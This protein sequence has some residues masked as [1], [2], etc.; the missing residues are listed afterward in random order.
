MAGCYG[1]HEAKAMASLEPR[2]MNH[3]SV[4]IRWKAGKQSSERLLPH[5]WK[6][7]DLQKA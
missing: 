3:D 1:E 4:F 2:S 7:A 5:P 6:T